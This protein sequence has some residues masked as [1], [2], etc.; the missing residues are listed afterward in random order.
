MISHNNFSCTV[1]LI[2]YVLQNCVIA[3]S[4][5]QQ[6]YTLKKRITE[7][8]T[9]KLKMLQAR[10]DKVCSWTV[11]VNA[12]YRPHPL[13]MAKQNSAYT[14][15]FAKHQQYFCTILCCMSN[16]RFIS[17]L[18]YDIVIYKHHKTIRYQL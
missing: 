15:Q 10:F 9:A 16:I 17:V 11:V 8:N 3:S 14:T 5:I 12:S 4:L 18:I 13:A 1:F 7:F 2:N 6:E